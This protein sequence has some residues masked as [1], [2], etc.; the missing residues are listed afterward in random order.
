MNA[1]NIGEEEYTIVI[2]IGQGSTKV[3][4]AGDE[5]PRSIFPTVTGKPKYQK[6]TGVNTQEIY[7]G[8]IYVKISG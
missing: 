8:D 3:G 2:D 4:Y 7:V 1:V 6:M 5:I